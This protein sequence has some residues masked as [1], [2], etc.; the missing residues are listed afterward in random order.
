MNEY[1]TRKSPNRSAVVHL[2][3]AVLLYGVD[4]FF[5]Q[6]GVAACAVALAMAIYGVVNVIRGLR[7]DSGIFWHGVTIF[8][9]YSVMFAVVIGT[10][11]AND[12]LAR[13]RGNRVAAALKR[14][15]D[16]RGACPA[17]LGELVPEYISSIPVTKYTLWANEFRYSEKHCMLWYTTFPPVGRR[18]YHVMDDAWN[19]P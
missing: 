18:V 15:K 16:E 14:F 17:E 9:I 2:V 11:W 1:T 8:A 6:Q 3:V 10:I 7:G 12:H 19:R 4:S 13:V 5:L